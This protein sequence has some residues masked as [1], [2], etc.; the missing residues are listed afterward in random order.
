MRTVLLGL[1]L[2][3]SGCATI[4]QGQRHPA[5]PWEGYNRAIFKF[6]DKLDQIVLKPVAKGY[7]KVTPD[8]V[9]TGVSNFFS[10]LFDVGVSLNNLLQGKPR[11]AGSDL[12]RF[13]MNSTFGIA[14]L[15]D[16]ASSAG[17]EKHNEDFG[18]TLA[19]WG[20]PSGPYFMLPFLGPS[21]IRDT[22][23]L[24]V[25]YY[26][27]YPWVFL[28]DDTARTGLTVLNFIDTR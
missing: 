9:E 5:D 6:N 16:V 28:E 13:V 23:A 1:L 24:S 26:T 17:L 4:P 3:L 7:Q 14:G 27:R 15:F 20:V 12:M 10:N 2:I 19:T 18:Q 25:D 21:T 11:R 8:I 22:G